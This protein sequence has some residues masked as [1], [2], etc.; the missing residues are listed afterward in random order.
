MLWL[1]TLTPTIQS[2]QHASLCWLLMVLQA[3]AQQSPR[4]WGFYL[5]LAQSSIYDFFSKPRWHH[6]WLPWLIPLLCFDRSIPP[7]QHDYFHQRRTAEHLTVHSTWFCTSLQFFLSEECQ[8]SLWLRGDAGREKCA[9]GV[10][11]GDPEHHSCPSTWWI[12]IL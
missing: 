11:K 12:S 3:Q 2:F 8:L 9:G 1:A 7:F 10:K 6:E 4:L 5:N